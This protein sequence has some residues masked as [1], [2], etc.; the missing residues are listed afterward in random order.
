MRILC[1]IVIILF[2]HTDLFVE[3]LKRYKI[4]KAIIRKLKSKL[5]NAVIITQLVE[6][7]QT[8]I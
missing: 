4:K 7:L 3:E 5:I 1:K 2:V 6:V 8:L